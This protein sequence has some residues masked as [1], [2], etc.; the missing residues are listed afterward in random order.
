MEDDGGKIFKL[1]V[2]LIGWGAGVMY[3]Y[4]FRGIHDRSTQAFYNSSH[5]HQNSQE[6][7]K[8]DTVSS[9]RIPMKMDYPMKLD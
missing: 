6:T 7:S 2:F 5:A 3:G 8:P 1:I 9:W 4:S